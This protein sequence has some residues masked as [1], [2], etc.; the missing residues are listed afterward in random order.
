MGAQIHPQ[1]V[2]AV[3]WDFDR[4][5]APGAMQVP[6][7]EEYGV[8]GERFWREVGALPAHYGRLGV[9]VNPDSAYLNHLITYAAHGRMDRLTNAR[10]RELGARIELYQGLPEFFPHLQGAVGDV[11]DADRFELRLEHYVVSAGLK[12]MIEGSAIRPYVEGIWASEFI[13]APAQ[14][15]FDPDAAP[16]PE[17]GGAGEALFPVE[18]ISQ[19]AVA[20]D[21]TSKTR[22]LFEIN[23]GSNKDSAIDVNATMR[24]EDRRVPF[25]NMIYVADGPSDVPAF[26]VVRANRGTALAVYDCGDGKSIEQADALMRDGRV[27]H[28]SPADYRVGGPTAEWLCMRVRRIAGAIAERRREA[29]RKSVGAAPRHLPQ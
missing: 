13:E 17:G 3:V 8:D 9:K 21:N 27:D 24:P 22:A 5:L 26:S 16:G 2:V 6:I 29:L 19:I 28:F 1:N 4:T 15:G 23:K 7:F 11:P 14:P 25:E 10:L 20:Y 18:A 12:E